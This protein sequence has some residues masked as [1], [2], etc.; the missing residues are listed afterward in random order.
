MLPVGRGTNL[1]WIFLIA[2][3]TPCCPLCYMYIMCGG[4]TDL[5]SHLI[6]LG[7]LVGSLL[8][9]KSADQAS[10]S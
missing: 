10:V 8:S 3:H 2:V 1:P 4:V 5:M 6:L 7:H 9:E